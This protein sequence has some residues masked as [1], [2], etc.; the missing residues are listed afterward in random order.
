MRN[1]PRSGKK[2]V[3]MISFISRCTVVLVYAADLQIA[4]SWA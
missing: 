2:R 1:N 4:F 3:K